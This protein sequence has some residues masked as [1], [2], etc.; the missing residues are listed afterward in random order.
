MKEK[1]THLMKL[2]T[3]HEHGGKINLD[4]LLKTS[5]AFFEEMKEAFVHANPEEKK[6]IMSM[7]QQMHAALV[8]QS[9]KT[10]S[11]TGLREEEVAAFVQNPNN[12]TPEQWK[13]MEE[14]R[15]KIFS[16]SKEIS[17]HV[18]GLAKEKAAGPAGVLPQKKEAPK[19][20]PS[21]KKPKRD[22]WMKS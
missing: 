9:K 8:A 14:T 21:S 4:E 17:Q 10:Q 13:S 2:L 18:K 22:Q 11:L 16:S 20:P 1:F 7:V 15:E 12:F 5:V 19:S 3:Q 6:E